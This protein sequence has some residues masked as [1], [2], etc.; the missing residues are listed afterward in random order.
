MKHVF[1]AVITVI[2]VYVM[3]GCRASDSKAE[4]VITGKISI[5]VGDNSR[6]IALESDKESFNVYTKED[7]KYINTTVEN[8][9]IIWN[10]GHKYEIKGEVVDAST[11]KKASVY[12]KSMMA[13]YIKYIG[14]AA[15]PN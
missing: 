6:I 11:I 12:K 13:S 7:T 10:L 8:G 14:P 5:L 15:N 4:Q 9:N 1:V 3:L 2:A